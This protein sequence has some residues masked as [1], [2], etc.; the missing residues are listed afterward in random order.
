[1]PMPSFPF[2]IRSVGALAVA[3]F[4][5]VLLTGV[6]RTH[7]AWKTTS[8]VSG[9][10]VTSGCEE[11]SLFAV[12]RQTHGETVY[13]DSSR[14]PYS[15]AYFNWLFYRGYGTAATLGANPEDPV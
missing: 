15:S 1:M 2:A 13:L 11:E 5:G 10:N 6:M 9:L 14:P 4:L 12:W 3:V 8:P 7:S